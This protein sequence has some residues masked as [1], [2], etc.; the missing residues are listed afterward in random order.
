MRENTL[1]TVGVGVDFGTSN[2]SVAVADDLGPRVL[3]IDP[4]NDAPTSL[5][6]LLYMERDGGRVVGR[7]AAERYIERNTGRRV[8]MKRV[9]INRMIELAEVGE[10]DKEFMPREGLID[11]EV[12][13]GVRASAVV[14]AR[15]PGRFFH[16]LKPYLSNRQFVNTKVFGQPY[17]MEELVAFILEPA[18]KAVEASLGLVPDTVI[19]GRPVMFPGAPE[20]DLFAQD[21]LA[22][23]ARIAGFREVVFFYEPVAAC[24]EYAVTG[25]DRQRI[26]VAD[27]GGGTCDVSVMFFEVGEGEQSRLRNSRILSVSGVAVAGNAIDREILRS[28]V[29]PRLGSRA[30]YGPS[31]LPMPASLFESLLDW[32]QMY[33]LNTEEILHW[34]A[35][36]EASCDQPE[37]L[38]A[39]QQVIR[40]NLG[41]RLAREAEQAKKRLSAESETLLSLLFDGLQIQELLDR[42]R[43]AHLIEEELTAIEECLAE[44]ETSAEIRP[45]DVDL[46]L[47]TGGSSLVPAIRELLIRRYGADRVISRDAF[48]S[49]AAGLAIAARFLDA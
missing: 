43:F 10:P 14:E 8:R 6:S 33:T 31:R 35:A 21:R 17:Q 44:A 24:L 27:I 5:P 38:R 15:P 20:D 7:L 2:T 37:A 25:H 45:Q 40:Y 42:T 29:F 13:Y 28:V 30:V 39:L 3:E 41:Y 32:Q 12:R 9:R 47:A 19:F 4:H 34:L 22:T 23:A 16:S 49:V 36:A 11:P 46:V 1:G 18:R 26:L 48:T